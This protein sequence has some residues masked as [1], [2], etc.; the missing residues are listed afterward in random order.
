MRRTLVA[1]ATAFALIPILLAG[2]SDSGDSGDAGDN[3]TETA[4]IVALTADQIAQ[5]VLQP[6]NLGDGWTSEP[7]TDDEGAAPGCLADVEALTDQLP[8]QDRGGTEFSYGDTLQVESTV[9]T[10]ADQTAIAAIFDQVQ[11]VVA[12]CTTVTGPDSNG[13]EWDLSLTT[14]DEV[15]YDDVDDQ[16]RLSGSGIVTTPSGA[17]FDIYVEQ[18]AVRVGPNVGSISTSDTQPRA[19]EHTTWAEIAVARLRAVAA[20]NEPEATTAPAPA[21]TS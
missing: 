18:T 7:S 14:S 16:Y 6:E 3:A 4:A 19:T 1:P 5:A 15:V 11:T 9:S 13:N 21:T 8:R 2:C 12:A 17:E 10:Y 20:G